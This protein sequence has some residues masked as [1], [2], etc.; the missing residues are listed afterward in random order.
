MAPTV[1]RQCQVGVPRRGARPPRYGGHTDCKWQ[2]RQ[3]DRYSSQY[4]DSYHEPYQK[5]YPT[6][7]FRPH[8]ALYEDQSSYGCQSPECYRQKFNQHYQDSCRMSSRLAYQKHYHSPYPQQYQRQFQE[9]N[10]KQYRHRLMEQYQMQHQRSTQSN[11]H[12]FDRDRRMEFKNQIYG[13]LWP[14]ARQYGGMGPSNFSC[15]PVGFPTCANRMVPDNNQPACSRGQ[16]SRSCE[17]SEPRRAC[18]GATCCRNRNDSR[19]PSITRSHSKL[20]RGQSCASVGNDAYCKPHNSY[21]SRQNHA[22]YGRTTQTRSACP[23]KSRDAACQYSHS[24]D[25]AYMT[26]DSLSR[27]RCDSYSDTQ[28][29]HKSVTRAPSRCEPGCFGTPEKKCTK[30]PPAQLQFPPSSCCGSCFSQ[31]EK[32]KSRRHVSNSEHRRQSRSDPFCEPCYDPYQEDQSA[33]CWQLR[34][35]P[36]S[37]HRYAHKTEAPPKSS[38]Q[39]RPRCEG[40]YEPR[41]QPEPRRSKSACSC[42][43]GPRPVTESLFSCCPPEK[44][45]DY[46]EHKQFTTMAHRNPLVV[47]SHGCLSE[48]PTQGYRKKTKKSRDPRAKSNYGTYG[49]LP[50]KAP[51]HA[52]PGNQGRDYYGNPR[53]DYA[54]LQYQSGRFVRSPLTVSSCSCNM[55][56][57]V[58]P[59]AP[60]KAVKERK[61]TPYSSY[62]TFDEA[63]GPCACPPQAPRKEFGRRHTSFYLDEAKELPC[64]C[65][66]NGLPALNNNNSP[67][68]N[69]VPAMWFNGSS[70]PGKTPTSSRNERSY[71]GLSPIA[72]SFIQRRQVPAKSCHLGSAPHGSLPL[73][74]QRGSLPKRRLSGCGTCNVNKKCLG[75]HIKNRRCTGKLCSS[76]GSNKK[77][78]LLSISNLLKARRMPKANPGALRL[79]IKVHKLLDCTGVKIKL[80]K[81]RCRGGKLSQAGNSPQGARNA[82]SRPRENQIGGT[83]AMP[84]AQPKPSRQQTTV[85]SDR[86]QGQGQSQ[87]PARLQQDAEYPREQH[88]QPAVRPKP[89][90]AAARRDLPQRYQMQAPDQQSARPI[91]VTENIPASEGTTATRQPARN[92]PTAATGTEPTT[93]RE[94]IGASTDKREI[95]SI[96]NQNKNRVPERTEE[97]AREQ[98]KERVQNRAQERGAPRSEE[99]TL[100]RARKNNNEKQITTQ[101]PQYLRDGQ[102]QQLPQPIVHSHSRDGCMGTNIHHFYRGSFL[103]VRS[104]QIS[105]EGPSN[106]PGGS[107]R[108][109]S[110][111]TVATNMLKPRMV[112]KSLP[113][114]SAFVVPNKWQCTQQLNGFVGGSPIVELQK[115]K[116]L[117]ISGKSGWS[118]R[119]MLPS[120]LVNGKGK[121]TSA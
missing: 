8:H 92:A 95:A 79:P 42:G 5:Q 90:A 60:A 46:A 21:R 27:H 20:R 63:Q 55:Q 74:K 9:Q 26:P 96:Q 73:A 70:S 72:S 113:K 39:P 93:R 49:S 17:R 7:H 25:S 103:A 91:Q 54:E 98:V 19:S 68:T 32:Q 83:R 1:H 76:S 107:R 109:E 121:A 34:S 65:T 10:P 104:T 13:H 101:R 57:S 31:P 62:Q 108:R 84:G 69:F 66:G 48:C 43:F 40:C 117:H 111:L 106:G 110:L 56:P 51:K 64:R 82:S 94:T 47:R 18:N 35:E 50:C 115:V 100:Q 59:Q 61:A 67:R 81:Q 30:Q 45:T 87:R 2:Q 4:S 15:N 118:W 116:G 77:L 58:M 80:H 97:R 112:K 22:D 105:D 88:P 41:P 6:E 99:N 23:S 16:R 14:P 3:E 29:K 44:P 38:K 11:S 78:P 75:L 53:S 114:C 89:P 102:V 86:V 33:G 28:K 120:W 52:R 37:E 36:R 24:V 12:T 119:K 85:R 71:S